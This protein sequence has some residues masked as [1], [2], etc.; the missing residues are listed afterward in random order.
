ME[1]LEAVS[2]FSGLNCGLFHIAADAGFRC[3][4]AFLPAGFCD[5]YIHHC[6]KTD[7]RRPGVGLALPGV[8]YTDDQRRAVFLH[9]NFGAVPG[10]DLSGGEKAPHLFGEGETVGDVI[11]IYDCLNFILTL[12]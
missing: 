12:S 3:R 6:E 5:D 1:L 2:I 11:T 8:Y 4:G 10:Q 9:R 7:L